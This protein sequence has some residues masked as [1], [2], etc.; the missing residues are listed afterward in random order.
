[1]NLS[2]RIDAFVKL[3][4]LINALLTGNS[5]SHTH[6]L[7]QLIIKTYKEN[8]WFDKRHIKFALKQTALNLK[9]EKI[10]NWLKPYDLHKLDLSISHEVAVIMAGNIPLVGFH[11]FLCVL[12]S[13]YNVLIKTSAQDSV[14]IKYVSKELCKIQPAFKTKIG[15]GTLEDLKQACAL[16]ATGGDNTARYFEYHF[17]HLPSIIRKNRMSI[18]VLSGLEDEKALKRLSKDICLYYNRGCRSISHVFVPN[19]FEI[20]KLTHNLSSFSFLLNN[21]KFLNNFRYS[22]AILTIDGEYFTD[23]APFLF[24]QNTT[25]QSLGIVNY[26][27]YNTIKEVNQ[28]IEMNKDKIQCVVSEKS[29]IANAIP[30]GKAQTPNLNN[31]ADGRDT[32]SFLLTLKK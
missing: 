7:N 31:Y 16:I 13:G 9:R 24:S 1:M 14:L 12:L 27:F 21:N 6:T 30:F 17:S 19:G 5:V 23:T 25:Y 3:G 26:S 22:K 32:L 8:P 15:F 29:L 2:D 10:N 18:A 4:D 11:D 28:Y 20:E